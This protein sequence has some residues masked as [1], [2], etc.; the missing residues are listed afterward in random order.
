MR[1]ETLT[2]PE[3]VC[4]EETHVPVAPVTPKIMNDVKTNKSGKDEIHCGPQRKN[5]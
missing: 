5:R 1:D 2:E 3:N 4:E